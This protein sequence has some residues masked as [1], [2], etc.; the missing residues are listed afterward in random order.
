MRCVTLVSVYILWQL[1]REYGEF[2]LIGVY[3]Y[4]PS[5]DSIS[6][7]LRHWAVCTA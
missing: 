5:L 3:F 2:N 1:K 4:G 6:R 7:S